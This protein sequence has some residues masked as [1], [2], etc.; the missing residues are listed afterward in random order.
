M[1]TETGEWREA[2]AEEEVGRDL[3]HLVGVFLHPHPGQV[4][5]GE[6]HGQLET[7]RIHDLSGEHAQHG[8]AVGPLRK[9]EQ[10]IR[11]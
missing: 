8:L 7:L 10:G 4:G 5:L 9:T 11:Q 3:A 2:E 1:T 6:R